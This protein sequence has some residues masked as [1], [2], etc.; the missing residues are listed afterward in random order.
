M[1][2]NDFPILTKINKQYKKYVSIKYKNKFLIDNSI[3]LKDT[4]YSQFNASKEEVN[5]IINSNLKDGE[6]KFIVKVNINNSSYK[7]ENNEKMIYECLISRISYLVEN[8][9][10]IKYVDDEYEKYKS[11]KLL[12]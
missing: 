2:L 1:N 8:F 11:K 3:K 6:I 5:N 4:F 7:M 12:S 9:N 10:N